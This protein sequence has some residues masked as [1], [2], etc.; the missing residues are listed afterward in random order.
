MSPWIK[1]AAA[2]ALEVCATLALRQSDGFSKPGWTILMIVGYLLAFYILSKITSELAI[3]TIYAV[4]SGAG[5]AVVAAIGIWIFDE[6]LTALRVGGI[7]LIVLG[8]VAL[9]LG[10]SGHGEQAQGGTPSTAPVPETT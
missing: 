3:G 1:L 7:V 9:N 8:V 4:W 5:T 6:E 2:I 10:G